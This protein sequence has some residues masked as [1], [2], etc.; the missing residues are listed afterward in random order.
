MLD[1]IKVNNTNELNILI[2]NWFLQLQTCKRIELEDTFS[3]ENVG[4]MRTWGTDGCLFDSC[5]R[6]LLIL[7]LLLLLMLLLLFLQLDTN[8]KVYCDLTVDSYHTMYIMILK[9]N[10]TGQTG[11]TFILVIFKREPFFPTYFHLKMV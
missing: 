3:A 10:A 7:I 6:L 9:K 4:L 2:F 8:F 11:W 1:K 5:L